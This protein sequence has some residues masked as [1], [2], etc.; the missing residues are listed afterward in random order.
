MSDRSNA[1]NSFDLEDMDKLRKRL[2]SSLKDY[3]IF[4]A[5]VTVYD[6]TGSYLVGSLFYDVEADGWRW[7]VSCYGKDS[8]A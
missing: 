1:I 2:V 6:S 4:D 5:E 8:K 7:D 3:T